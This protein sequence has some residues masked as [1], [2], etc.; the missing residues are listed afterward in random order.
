MTTRAS[1]RPPKG[2]TE[3]DETVYTAIL[4]AI[5]AGRLVAGTKLAETPL[6]ELFGVSRERIR[7]V[8]HRLV[9]ERRLEAVT[10]RGVRVPCPTPDDVRAIY[11]AHRVLEAGIL[12]E[13]ASRLDD[14]LLG[15]LADH[16]AC[17]RQAAAD[18]DRAA[19]VRLSGQFHLLIADSLGN[20]ELSAALRDLLSRSS[21]MV[22]VFEAATD[23]ICGANEHA[24]IVEALRARDTARAIALSGDHF[25]HI[26]TR[27]RLK[28]PSGGR[29]DLPAIF[30]PPAPAG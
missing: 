27:L 10:N 1:K 15:R 16:I 17:E 25:R 18:G 11:Q 13:L 2:D 30:R 4:D 29:P 14:A 8:L 23:S 21:V 24:A 9:A 3:A 28:M 20:A 6:A 12:V 5:L 19:S 7:K 26:E 22:S